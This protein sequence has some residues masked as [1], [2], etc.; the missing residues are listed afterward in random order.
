MIPVPETMKVCLFT[1]AVPSFCRV[2]LC[3]SS[4]ARIQNQAGAVFNLCVSLDAGL[5]RPADVPAEGDGGGTRRRKKA[6][7]PQYASNAKRPLLMK[8]YPSPLQPTAS[9]SSPV[10]FL[11]TM[12]TASNGVKIQPKATAVETA[13]GSGAAAAGDAW[14]LNSYQR[15]K[16]RDAMKYKCEECGRGFPISSLLQRHIKSHSADNKLLCR[17]CGKSYG[18]KTTLNYH[19]FSKHLGRGFSISFIIFHSFFRCVN[20]FASVVVERSRTF[21]LEPESVK[22]HRLRAVAV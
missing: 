5:V 10:I 7:R 8:S 11:M 22:M 2:E 20:S 12:P 14:Q 13:S 15:A 4:L 1:V 6:A 3:A 17:Y 9:S 18:S 21:L 19:I 16:M